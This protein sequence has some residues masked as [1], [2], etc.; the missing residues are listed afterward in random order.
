[1]NEKTLLKVAIFVSIIGLILLFFFTEEIKLVPTGNFDELK[2][3]EEVMVQGRVSK[4]SQMEKVA[5][6][7]VDNEKVEKTKVILF[8]DHDVWLKAGDYVEVIG[9]VEEYENEMEII[10]NKVTVKGR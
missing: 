3:E 8:K 9:T 4:V 5:F 7:E 1:V 10:A 6:L 2:V